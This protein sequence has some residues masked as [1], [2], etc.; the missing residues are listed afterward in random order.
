MRKKALKRRIEDIKARNAFLDEVLRSLMYTVN[1]PRGHYAISALLNH[2]TAKEVEMI[3]AFWKWAD[4]QDRSTLTKEA[5]IRAFD[6]R[7]PM[8]LRGQ[9]S[10][11]LEDH[12][13]DQT[14]QFL[15]YADLVLGK[16]GP[17]GA[18]ER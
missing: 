5:L 15:H 14:P 8:K 9:L 12:R 17:P 1:P 11:M 10:Q 7:M 18:Q 4:M 3:D 13:K 2:L 6:A 16:E